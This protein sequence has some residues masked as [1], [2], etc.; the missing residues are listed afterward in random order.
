MVLREFFDF[1]GP[2]KKGAPGPHG[3]RRSKPPYWLHL[4]SSWQNRS[5]EI[6][7]C[8]WF[9]NIAFF[10]IVSSLFNSGTS[11]F[12]ADIL[13]LFINLLMNMIYDVC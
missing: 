11:I 12:A 5:A 6:F 9:V 8:V 1:Q 2:K 7:W 10:H 4:R 3:L 13:K